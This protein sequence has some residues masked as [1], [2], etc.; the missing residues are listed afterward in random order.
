V[1]T[2]TKVH[3]R[4]LFL[5]LLATVLGAET[6]VCKDV[7]GNVTSSVGAWTVRCW[8]SA[9]D[10]LSFREVNL[11]LLTHVSFRFLETATILS[12]FSISLH[13]PH[14]AATAAHPKK[15]S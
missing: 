13:L 8:S 3:A 12:I 15:I 4:D 5:S 14:H 11:N 2:S 1:A 6:P 9:L 10:A 7:V